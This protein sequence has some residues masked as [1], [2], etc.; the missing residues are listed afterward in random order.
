M[1]E[2]Q[3]I[4]NA[5]FIRSTLRKDDEIGQIVEALV[6]KAAE[7]AERV[8]SLEELEGE[9]FPDANVTILKKCPMEPVLAVI[10][11]EQL[12]QTGREE[13]PGFYQVI[14]NKFIE[15]QPDDAAV[16]HP[17]CIV[18]QAMRD[19][20]GSQKGSLTRQVACRSAASGAVVFSKNGLASANLTAARAREKINGYA[21]MYIQKK[22]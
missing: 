17:L 2:L 12:A 6:L 1:A 19:I 9:S 10:K 20:V 22:L 8:G 7:E 18:H 3:R 4:C 21:C 11:K 15:E 14:V 13:L 16:L 5:D